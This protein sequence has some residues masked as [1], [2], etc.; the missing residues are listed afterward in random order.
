MSDDEAIKQYLDPKT[1]YWGKSK[2]LKKYR[3]TLN[4]LYSLQRHKRVTIKDKR[5]Q[6]R[7]ESAS[8]PFQ[9]VQVDLA[10]FVKLKRYNGGY[11]YLLVCIDVFS[12]YLWLKPLKSKYE[13]HIPLKQ[14]LQQMKSKFGK[15]PETMTGDNEFDTNGLQSLA[16]QYNFDWYFGDAHEK[17]R[18]GIVE[19]VIGTIRNLIKRYTMQNNTA[20]YIDVLN[21]LT[22]NYNDT[23]HDSIR[24]RPSTALTTGQT[25]PKPFNVKKIDTLQIGDKVRVLLPRDKFTKGSEPYY[26]EHIYEIVKIVKNR[27]KVRNLEYDGDEKTLGLKR[28]MTY[29][30]HQLLRVSQVNKQTRNQSVSYSNNKNNESSVSFDDKM[31]NVRRANRN[32]RRLNVMGID[33]NNI[34]DK[35]ERDAL[36][37]QLDVIDENKPISQKQFSKAQNILNKEI[38]NQISY[39]ERDKKKYKRSDNNL[40]LSRIDKNIQNLKKQKNQRGASKHV[41]EPIPY[42]NLIPKTKQKKNKR[43]EVEKRKQLIRKRRLKAMK[44]KIQKHKKKKKVTEKIQTLRRST[45]NRRKP[46]WYKPPDNRK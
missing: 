8:Y 21:D 27:Y 10:D 23:I 14:I 4:K 38:D 1:G 44:D 2:M 31:R 7:R 3:A 13:L 11:R 37:Q 33:L 9:A 29:G 46:D 43:D 22:E 28:N 6:Y 40:L 42:T 36:K 24:S 12:R 18:T 5:K 35:N 26:S 41:P 30:R 34:I 32:K 15:T 39:Y 25:F 19:R 20:K 17:F 45:R 16:T